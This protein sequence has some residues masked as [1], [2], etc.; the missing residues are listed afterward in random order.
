MI[1]FISGIL[2][3]SVHVITGPDH[4]A[5]VTPLA[6]ENRNKAWHIG[7]FWGIGHVL[8]MLLIGGLYLIFREFINV[9]RISA[10]SEFLV[11]FVLIGIG[12]WAILKVYGRFHIHHKHPHVHT[13]PEPIVHIHTHQHSD[14]LNHAHQHAG[15]KRQN[16]LT[17][18]MIGTLHGFAGI[19]HFLLILPTLT[20]PTYKDSILYLGGFGIGTIGT[21]VAYALAL[22]YLSVRSAGAGNARFFK[23]LRLGAGIAAILVGLFWVWKAA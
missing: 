14:E 20:L 8:G 11:G 1:Q 15:I 6:I 2:M 4:L 23:S 19:S 18:V 12:T 9:D 3:S 5:A 10:Y 17:A 16:N 7:L 13:Q 21:M 22:G